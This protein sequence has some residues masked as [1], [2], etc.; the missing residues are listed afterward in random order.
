MDN[1]EKAE[2]FMTA[3]KQLTDA[4]PQEVRTAAL[5]LK[6]AVQ[7]ADYEKTTTAYETLMGL[8]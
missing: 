5:R 1:W 3:V 7:K 4:A 8:L 6:M 2:T